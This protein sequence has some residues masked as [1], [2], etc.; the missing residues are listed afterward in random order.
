VILDEGTCHLDPTAEARAEAAL[1][2]R[3][4]TLVVIA[5]RLSSALRADRILVLDGSRPA[6]GTH[7]AL[8]ATSALYRDLVGHWTDSSR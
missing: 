8:V 5:H 6:V 4:G 2:A 1:A 7:R 3:P